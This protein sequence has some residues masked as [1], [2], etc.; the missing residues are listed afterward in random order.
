MQDSLLDDEQNMLESDELAAQ[1]AFEIV[2][3]ATQR[4]IRTAE[5]E[6]WQAHVLTSKKRYDKNF[7]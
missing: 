6:A 1:S 2:T 3:Q 7:F 5:E 4:K